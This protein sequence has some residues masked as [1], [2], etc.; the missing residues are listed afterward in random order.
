MY[1][2][3]DTKDTPTTAAWPGPHDDQKKL[4]V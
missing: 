3:V 4:R 1:I 2:L